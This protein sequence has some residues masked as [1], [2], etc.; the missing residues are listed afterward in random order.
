MNDARIYES[1]RAFG[2]PN[3]RGARIKI[4]PTFQPRSVVRDASGL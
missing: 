4:N 2:V 1:V 3:Y